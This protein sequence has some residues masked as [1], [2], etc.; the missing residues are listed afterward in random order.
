MRFNQLKHDPNSIMRK[1]LVKS[2]KNWI[3]VA[4]LSLAGGIF[5]MGTPS[6]NVKADTMPTQINSAKSSTATKSP[7]DSLTTAKNNTTTQSTTVDNNQASTGATNESKSTTDV[8]ESPTTSVS[9]STNNE[10]KTNPANTVENNLAKSKTQLESLGVTP[11]EFSADTNTDTTNTN[12]AQGVQGTTPWFIS[13]DGSLHLGDS[14]QTTALSDNTTTTTDKVSGSSSAETATTPTTTTAVTPSD[15]SSTGTNSNTNAASTTTNTAPS[16]GTSNTTQKQSSTNSDT[17]Q[18]SNPDNS[19]STTSTINT[20]TTTSVATSPWQK[21]ANNINNITFD[22]K[23]TGA[24]DMNHMFSDLSNLT[25]INNINQLDTSNTENVSGLFANDTKLT[26]VTGSK[27][28]DGVVDLS[29]LNLTSVTDTSDMFLDDSSIQDITFP[30]RATTIKKSTN[31]NYMFKNDISLNALDVSNWQ[32]SYA[33]TMLG[34]F[35]NDKSLKNLSIS[36]WNMDT[37]PDTGDSSKN[38]G[39]FDGTDLQSIKLSSANTFKIYTALPSSKSNGWTNGSVAFS[40]EPN[41]GNNYTYNLNSIKGQLSLRA[42]T[43]TP[44]SASDPTVPTYTVTLTV[45]TSLGNQTFTHTGTLNSSFS[46]TPNTYPG[47]TPDISTI[48]AT[49]TS[50]IQA[51]T[52]YYI[53]YVGNLVGQWSVNG[54]NSPTGQT[55]TVTGTTSSTGDPARIGDTFYINPDTTNTGYTVSKVG[56]GLISTDDNGNPTYSLLTQPEYVGIN[57]PESSAQFSTTTGVTKNVTIPKG[58]YGNTSTTI[59]VPNIPGYTLSADSPKTLNVVYN[60]NGTSSVDTSKVTYI[61]N[62]V[63]TWTANNVKGPDNTTVSASGTTNSDD[64]TAKIGDTVS[65][66]PDVSGTGYYVE[67]PGVGVIKAN[68]T[69][70]APEVDITTQPTY[71]PITINASSVTFKTKTS[72]AT[73]TIPA[74]QYGNTTTTIKTPDIPGYTLSTD[75]PKTLQVTYNKNGTSSVDTSSVTY[76]PNT[77]SSWTASD[78]KGPDDTTVS[79][80]GTTNSDN[81]TA[82]IGDTVSINPDVNGTGYQVATPGTGTIII[83]SKTGEPTIRIDNQPTYEPITIPKSSITFTTPTGVTKAVEIPEGQYGNTATM[84]TV[85]DI[86]GYTL[87]ADS[88]KNLQVTYNKNGTSSVDTSK[89]TYIPN[90]VTSWTVDNVKGPENITVSASGTTNIDNTTAKIGD[91]VSINPDVTGTGYQVATPGV[92]VIKANTTT[93]APEIDITTEPTYEP[94]TIPKSSVIFTAASGSTSK[95][96]IPEGKYGNTTTTIEVP[97]IPGYTLSSDSPKTLQVKYNKDGTSSVDISLVKYIPN[98][99][100]SWTVN[101]VVGPDNT[102]I[103]VSGSTNSNNTTAKIGDTVSINPDVA[104]TGYQVDKPGTGTIVANSITGQPEIKI[105][106]NPS[107]IPIPIPSS[108]QTIT[109]KDGT[110][111]QVTIPSGDVTVKN[112]TINVP[113]I[114]GYTA[115]ESTL[116]VSYNKDGSVTVD[117]SN[118]TYTPNNVPNWSTTVTDPTGKTIQVSGTNAKVGQTVTLSPNIPGYDTTSG[119]AVIKANSDGST[120]LD[121]TKAPTYAPTKVPTWSTNV[122]GP[123]AGSQIKINGTDVH[124]GQTITL[125]PNTDNLGYTVSQ[126]GKG[127]VAVDKDGNFYISVTQQPSYT[128]DSVKNWQTT[129]TL[130]N[131]QTMQV[132][133]NTNSDNQSAKF[134]DTVTI[135][136]EVPGYQVTPGTGIIV[137]DKNGQPTIQIITEPKFTKIPSTTTTQPMIQ[138]IHTNI[139]THPNS[140]NIPIYQWNYDNMSILKNQQLAP[141]TDWFTD[142]TIVV[143]GIKYYRIATNEWVKASQVYPY[144][145]LDIHIRTYDKTTK[146]L[147]ESA[148][149][150]VGN[151]E[152]QPN[153]SWYSNQTAYFINGEK[154]YRIAD[155]EFVKASDAYVYQPTDMTV[156]VKNDTPIQNLY[157]AKGQLITNRSLVADSDWFVDSIVYINGIKYYRVATD[158]FVKAS[159]VGIDY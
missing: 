77:V 131:H 49:I 57:I 88:P 112:Q 21:Y 20:A 11:S 119:T 99:V 78:I 36:S 19:N 151:R 75:S 80:S 68:T 110:K 23:V 155:G 94:I 149:Q 30:E 154:Y 137:A 74:G 50:T 123:T 114:P 53:N 93:G 33:K 8:A 14:T 86:P 52:N 125:N 126:P 71:K 130:P 87:S 141:Q 29:D 5:L 70:G 153:S 115:S 133:G 61:P 2:K 152:I 56:S 43:F 48:V 15:T 66:N 79:A 158:E 109:T 104:G 145:D 69:T 106:T 51:T 92:A 54:V 37:D 159:D 122:N 17:A 96:S 97:A 27:T 135:N 142:Q 6:L 18:N 111:I 34:M 58:Q 117:S 143:S 102:T 26:T 127:I 108:T 84:I 10:T 146:V 55:M 38:E 90:T 73:V 147:Y 85:P 3:V 65:I 116:P 31:F 89:V 59:I 156:R 95:V 4:S 13:A 140:G 113:K 16:T 91:T 12:I 42:T 132:S 35:Q 105:T 7:T 72:S 60:K 39:M 25:T 47:Y 100:P 107:Y 124:Y 103:S 136:P 121:I 41:A 150:I 32:F 101:G 64:T 44:N 28:T 118:L 45:P 82:K 120:F 1:K 40:A 129:I 81:A 139:S 76:V 83:D 144:R 134:G 98:T 9:T 128:A 62:T 138:K 22:G 46:V 63:P 148:D 67:K 24:D 157:T